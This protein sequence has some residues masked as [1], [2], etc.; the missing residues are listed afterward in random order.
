MK[1]GLRISTSE[2]F[3][4][5]ADEWLSW[6]KS[7]LK[8]SSIVRY[9]SILDR[10]LL[11]TFG[12]QELSS[13]TREQAISFQQSLLRSS[14]EGRGLSP[15]TAAI[16]MTVFKNILQFARQCKGFSTS[17]LDNLPM[18]VPRKPLRVFS[19]SEQQRLCRYLL[20]RRDP[21]SLGI[22]VALYTGLRIGELSALRWE[23][24]SLEERSLHV[25]HTMQRLKTEGASRTSVI[26]TAPKSVSSLRT[27]PL[28]EFLLEPLRQ[29]RAPGNCYVL[30]ETEAYIEPR[31]L[32]NRFKSALI[33][34]G[35]APTGFH[36][37]RH[38][39]ATRCIEL[40]FDVK[41]LS[42][43]LGHANVNIT[44]NRYVH[45]SMEFKRE[46]MNRLESLMEF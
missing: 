22:V 11:P 26:I 35:I 19:R 31:S 4:S 27:I 34:C 20:S 38:T 46:N 30:T 37:C 25:R 9:R 45:P 13:L 39:F 43:I 42:E 16:V 15:G 21:G 18:K 44:M 29:I 10:Y 23:D 40:G 24:V 3:T 1:D 6:K 12:D 33:S 41:S 2:N 5:I 17:D 32:E 36:T 7:S 28:P 14:A 8:E